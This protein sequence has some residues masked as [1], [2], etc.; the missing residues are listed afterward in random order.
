MATAEDAPT[1]TPMADLADGVEH[2][3]TAAREMIRA[4]RSLLDAAEGI[5]E[6]RDALHQVAGTLQGLAGA[7]ASWLRSSSAPG[8]PDS[9]GSEHKVQ[10]IKLS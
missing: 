7:A 5:V 8:D 4:A 1:D 6:D 2:L 3:Q 10:N 9:D